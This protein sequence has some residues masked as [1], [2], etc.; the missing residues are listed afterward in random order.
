MVQSL[1]I[2]VAFVEEERLRRSE[3]GKKKKL[4]IL[5]VQAHVVQPT[6][7]VPRPDNEIKKVEVPRLVVEVKEVGVPSQAVDVAKVELPRRVA[8][9]PMPTAEVVKENDV[10]AQVISEEVVFATEKSC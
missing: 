10:L 1:N 5:K 2:L 7:E 4:E 9:V 3:R 6:T 8:D